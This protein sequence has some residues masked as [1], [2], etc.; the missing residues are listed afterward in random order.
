MILPDQLGPRKT[1]LLKETELMLHGE[2]GVV[3]I[4]GRLIQRALP[5]QA[6]IF[7]KENSI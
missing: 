2:R 4:G 1:G 6:F 7:A 3:V 5:K